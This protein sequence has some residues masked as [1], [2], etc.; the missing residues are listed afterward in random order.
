MLGTCHLHVELFFTL[1]Y[2]QLQSLLCWDDYCR[3]AREAFG[4]S[5]REREDNVRL[6]DEEMSHKESM[7]MYVVAS[8]IGAIAWIVGMTAWIIVYTQ[9]R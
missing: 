5:K 7:R 1:A 8:G 9:N 3:F 4:K 2:V 6:F